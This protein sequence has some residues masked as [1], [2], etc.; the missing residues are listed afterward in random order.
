MYLSDNQ[1][2]SIL[3]AVFVVT[4]VALCVVIGWPNES[5]QTQQNITTA[6]NNG[7]DP[8]KATCLYDSKARELDVC[9]NVK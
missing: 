5:Q 8:I 4:F 7:I 9:K 3:I 1:L 2:L 6:I